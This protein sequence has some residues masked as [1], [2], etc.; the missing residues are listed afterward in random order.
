[1]GRR[2]REEGGVGWGGVGV[3]CG[4]SNQS[5]GCEDGRGFVL[6]VRIAPFL[7]PVFRAQRPSQ[8][9]ASLPFVTLPVVPGADT[10]KSRYDKIIMSSE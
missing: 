10:R 1:M 4:G 7:L 6:G 8:I 3:G 2:E 5:R 9:L